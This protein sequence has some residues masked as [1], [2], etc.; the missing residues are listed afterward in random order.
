MLSMYTYYKESQKYYSITGKQILRIGA[1]LIF[2]SN[3]LKNPIL[4][5]HRFFKFRNVCFEKVPEVSSVTK[6][7]VYIEFAS[8]ESLPKILQTVHAS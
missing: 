8:L 2:L 5:F 3:I 4:Q 1:S 6:E 7:S